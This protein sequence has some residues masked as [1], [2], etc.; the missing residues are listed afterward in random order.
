MNINTVFTNKPSPRPEPSR[1]EPSRVDNARP[2]ASRPEPSR[3]EPSRVDASRSNATRSRRASSTDTA[4]RTDETEASDNESNV[5]EVRKPTRAE[6]A[7]L[8]SLLAGAGPKVR[9]DLMKQMTVGDASLI[10]KLLQG[11]AEEGASLLSGSDLLTS[12]TPTGAMS[13][14]DV[15][16]AAMQR[17]RGTTDALRYGILKD[18]TA[19]GE[20][21][22]IDLAGFGAPS[23]QPS[24][25]ELRGLARA[26]QSASDHGRGREVLSR[27]VARRGASVD[28]LKALGENDAAGVRVAL[29]ALLS[30]AGT[31]AGLELASAGDNAAMSAA[32]TAAATALA[33]ANAASAADVT[34]PIRTV[35]PLA[36]ELRSRLERVV[37]RM[38]GEFGHDVSIV[39]T[40]RS[41]ERQDFL[42][43]QGRTR[44]G[45]VVT[46][47]RDSAHTRGEAVDVVVDGKY[48]NPEGFSRLQRIAA[49]EGLK[50]LGARD[51][52]HLEL[53]SD[54]PRDNGARVAS[55][56][57]REF[58]AVP[59]IVTNANQA[60][61][62]RVA[63]TA[64]TAG[65]ASVAGVADTASSRGFDRSYSPVSSSAPA[66]V[67]MAGPANTNGQGHAS[68]RGERD[69][70]GRSTNEGRK[71]GSAR[72]ETLGAT[73]SAAFGAQ[74]PTMTSAPTDA[75]STPA[76]VAA[77]STDRV[78]ELQDLRDSAPAG[79]VSRM[80]LN[81]D[82]PDGGQD[83][84]TVDLRGASVAT[85]ISTDASNA[86]RL[87]MRT[88][89]LQDALGRHG[90]ESDS[91]QISSAAKVES[92]DV[93]RAIAGERDGIRLNAAQ[94]SAS[95]DG[96][97]NQGQRDRSANAREWDRPEQSRQ[98][99]EEQRDSA[100]QGA[101]QRGQRDSSNG[102]TT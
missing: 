8:L 62:A 63:G 66:T 102:S 24:P 98:S 29:D 43:D 93:S 21:S 38:K 9:T 60:G 68:G 54:G 1:S 2:D 56:V 17:A 58:K 85:Q 71:I 39:E 45:S 30:R 46:W 95:N 35:D 83:R 80:T 42:F 100:R 86:E 59:L 14:S 25:D 18:S 65:V 22:S 26:L 27:I 34:T 11:S 75:G 5:R 6:F 92:A 10:D 20:S 51:P 55:A 89:E 101:G 49:E 94:Q 50:T 96:A 90:L 23:M 84:I 99:R 79:A 81:V 87:R 41:Q 32:A 73:E 44:P 77:G 47:T 67:T 69:D 91:V 64:G 53:P 76:V 37:E 4:S 78:T 36:P 57:P 70:Q 31:P 12:S 52:G 33:Q 72:R 16:A 74:Q 28:Q 13:P 7:G 15:L 40:A 48:N 61:V 19:D 97:M 3:F 82:A 88:A